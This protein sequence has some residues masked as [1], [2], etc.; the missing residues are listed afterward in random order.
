MKCRLSISSLTWTP[1][2]VEIHWEGHNGR[3]T[4]YIWETTKVTTKMIINHACVISTP[5][6]PGCTPYSG[7]AGCAGLVMSATWNIVASQ[8]HTLLIASEQ[9]ANQRCA[10]GRFANWITKAKAINIECFEGLSANGPK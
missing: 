2:L 3:L 6:Y 10:T 1:P 5:L 8:R 4:T 7:N 9:Q